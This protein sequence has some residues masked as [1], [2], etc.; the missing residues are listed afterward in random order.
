MASDSTTVIRQSRLGRGRNPTSPLRVVCSLP[1]RTM[2]T[3]LFA[4]LHGMPS[5][6]AA[7]R[8]AGLVDR[9]IPVNRLE[10]A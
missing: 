8:L 4:R 9:T 1:S 3:L 5:P 10:R 6:T 2:A 7:H